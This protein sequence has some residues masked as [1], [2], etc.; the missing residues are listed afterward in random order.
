[1]RADIVCPKCDA[2]RFAVRLMKGQHGGKIGTHLNL[3]C[4]WC[5]HEIKFKLG[6]KE[7]AESKQH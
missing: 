1:M 4:C 3:A 7:N 5:K 2:S 6:G